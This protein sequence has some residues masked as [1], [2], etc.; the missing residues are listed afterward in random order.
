MTI[1]NIEASEDQGHYVAKVYQEQYERLRHYFLTQLGD[2]A[3]AERCI[4]EAMRRLSFFMEERDWE[5]EAEYIP[6]YVMR[7]AGLLCSRK[8]GEKIRR[9]AARGG[10]GKRGLFDKVRAEVV[11]GFKERVEFMKVFLGLRGH[12]GAHPSGV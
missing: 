9:S 8:L 7:I 2:E 11:R 10:E 6:V 1:V 12:G 4:E 3:E 5:A